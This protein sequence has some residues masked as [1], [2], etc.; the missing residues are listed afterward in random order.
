MLIQRTFVTSLGL[1]ALASAAFAQVP[2]AG[3]FARQTAAEYRQLGR[4]PESSRVLPPGAADPVREKRMPTKQ[5]VRGPEGTPS[6]SVWASKV[7]VEV[8]Q[9]VDLFAELSSPGKPA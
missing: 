3:Q 5:T 2:D 4:Y 6:L 9:P 8:A 1:C 7:S